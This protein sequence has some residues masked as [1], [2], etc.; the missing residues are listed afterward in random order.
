MQEQCHVHQGALQSKDKGCYD[1][2]HNIRDTG[3]DSL[4]STSNCNRRERNRSN[5]GR[6]ADIICRVKIERTVTCDNRRSSGE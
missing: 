6:S 5:A 1:V 3:T 2:S 4:S